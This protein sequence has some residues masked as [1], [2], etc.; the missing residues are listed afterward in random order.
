MLHYDIVLQSSIDL[1]QSKCLEDCT[2]RLI[3]S[4]SPA[5]TQQTEPLFK[6]PS[7]PNKLLQEAKSGTKAKE[8]CDF[9]SYTSIGCNPIFFLWPVENQ[10]K[11]P[12]VRTDSCDQSCAEACSCNLLL[13][14]SHGLQWLRCGISESL[15]IFPIIQYINDT[16]WVRWWITRS[17]HSFW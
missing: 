8:G 13:Q 1:L 7:L 5:G 3:P 16:L 6:L 15:L 11:M 2:P 14:W 4:F 17:H 9:M 10:W 12:Q